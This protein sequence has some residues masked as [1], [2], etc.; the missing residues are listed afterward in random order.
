MAEPTSLA[1][2]F[3]AYDE[4]RGDTA[5][6]A[7]AFE[8]ALR[9]VARDVDPACVREDLEADLE[10]VRQTREPAGSLFGDARAYAEELYDRRVSDGRLGL[11]PETVAWR[12]VPSLGLGIGAALA[13]LGAPG[14]RLDGATTGWGVGWPSSP[15]CWAWAPPRRWRR[16]TR[17]SPAARSRARWRPSRASGCC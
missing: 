12:E 14:L 6:G 15:A 3:E 7:W 10:V 2:V 11:A 8:V 17:S 16:G 5:D 13:A 9:L 4:A 1:P